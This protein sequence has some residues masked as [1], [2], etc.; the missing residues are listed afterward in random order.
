EE[1]AVLMIESNL[2]VFQKIVAVLV[3]DRDAKPTI[4]LQNVFLKQPV[5][6]T[7]AEI[8]S[9]LAVAAGNA[10][11]D[12]RPLRAAPGVKAKP[13]VVLAHAV[14]HQHIVGLLE[15]DVVAVVIPH[16]A[17]LDYRAKA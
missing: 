2:V 7:P 12:H 4:V 1:N 5:P 6:N 15:T 3:A 16:H 8:E 14:L 11:A 13:G 17:I 9:V 10:L